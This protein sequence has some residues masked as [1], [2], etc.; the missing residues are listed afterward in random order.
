MNDMLNKFKSQLDSIITSVI[1]LGVI[2]CLS[3][4]CYNNNPE[5]MLYGNWG[6]TETASEGVSYILSFH[7][8]GVYYDSNTGNEPWNYQYIE[9]DSLILY[10]HVLYEERYR[11]LSL[12]KDTLVVRLSES[13]FH[14]VDNGEEIEAHYGDGSMP[15]YTYVRLH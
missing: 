7:R 11:I 2:I 14:A 15:I 1:V 9:P 12:T 4:S 5:T 10:H 8:T 13:I 6:M 3:I